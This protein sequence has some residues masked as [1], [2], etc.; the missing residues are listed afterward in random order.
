MRV[1]MR[2]KESKVIDYLFFVSPSPLVVEISCHK[3]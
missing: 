1:I 2:M 3:K